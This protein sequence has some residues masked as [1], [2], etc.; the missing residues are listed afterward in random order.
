MA[1]KFMSV[2]KYFIKKNN[3]FVMRLIKKLYW[4]IL[5]Y[6]NISTASQAIN[7]ENTFERWQNRSVRLRSLANIHVSMPTW[8]SDG[9]V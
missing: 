6:F 3:F 5:V 9:K 4:K 7:T 8:L 1:S 2:I